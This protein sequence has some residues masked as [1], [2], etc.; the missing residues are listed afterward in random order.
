MAK[1]LIHVN[2]NLWWFQFSRQG[3]ML[4]MP[5]YNR[6]REIGRLSGLLSEYLSCIDLMTLNF[7]YSRSLIW[8]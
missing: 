7:F 4:R 2:F 3:W 8:T 5:A 1:Y 6:K